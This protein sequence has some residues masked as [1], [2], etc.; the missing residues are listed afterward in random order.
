MKAT[1]EHDL[2]SFESTNKQKTISLA[3]A[4]ARKERPPA[5]KETEN[6]AEQDVDKTKARESGLNIKGAGLNSSDASVN[7]ADVENVEPKPEHKAEK[8]VP[9]TVA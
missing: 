1:I 5:L 4:K 9:E 3:K 7:K 8:E 2:T 6:L